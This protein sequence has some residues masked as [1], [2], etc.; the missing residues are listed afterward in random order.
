MAASST[1]PSP[2]APSGRA[3][4]PGATATLPAMAP[5]HRLPWRRAT[6]MEGEQ[7]RPAARTS[8]TS[9]GV[10]AW[11]RPTWQALGSQSSSPQG[12]A[13]PTLRRASACSPCGRSL[14]RGWLSSSSRVGCGRGS[15]AARAWRRA[16]TP[17]SARP[18]TMRRRA[19]RAASPSLASTACSSPPSSMSSPLSACAW[20]REALATS[21][22]STWRS[23]RA[24]ASLSFRASEASTTGAGGA[25]AAPSSFARPRAK[26]S[27]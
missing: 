14:W 9:T 15:G 26:R 2:W 1:P 25:R 13:T 20:S 8:S 12:I 5:H 16:S 10:G 24:R 6:R 17:P 11:T 21:A 22:R 7:G 18:S 3:Y 23:C 4:R 27:V 19:M